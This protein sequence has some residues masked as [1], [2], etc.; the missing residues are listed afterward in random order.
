MALATGAKLGPYEIVSRIGKGGM[1]E[2]WKARDPR[3]NR[4]VAIKI[5]AQQFTDR[6]EREARAIAALNHP[7]ICTLY[8]VG[9]NYLVMELVEGPTLAERIAQGP[10]PLEEALAIAKQIADALE[11]A[12]DKAIVHRDLK[13]GNVKI[14][15]DRQVKVLDFGL[16]KSGEIAE[17]TSDSP[18]MLTVAGMIL[19]TA[20]Y[21]APEQARGEVVDKRADIWAFGVVFYEMLAGKRLFDGKTVSDTLASVLMREPD[22][23]RIPAKVKRLLRAC[24]QKDARN[25]LQAIGDSRLLLE[26]EGPATEAAP[27][28]AAPSKKLRLY[29]SAA[30]L[31]AIVAL[32][33]TGWLFWLKAE[34]PARITRFQVP[35]PENTTFNTYLSLSPD[36]RKLVF[37]AT[38]TPGGLWIRDLEALEWRHL[39]GTEG[40]Q[41][42]FWSPDSRF[43]GFGVQNQLKK[44]EVS[45]GP[46]QTL[47]ANPAG[48]MGTGAWNRDG[49]IVFG[50]RGAGPLWKISQAGGVPTALTTIDSPRGETFHALPTFM[51][52]GKHFIYLRSGRPEVAGIYAGSVDAKPEQQ[53]RERILAVRLAASYVNGSLF[54]MRENTLM[55]QPF[56]T[57]RLQLRGDPVPVA[58]GLAIIG[59][60][61]VFSVSPGGALAY[62][63]GDQGAN[64]QLTWFDRQ[65]KI[66]S[67]FGQPGPDQSIVLSPDGTRGAVRDA[68]GGT[69]GDLWTLDF[70]RGVRTRFTFRQS[71]G[72]WGVWS[73]D[74]S[75][76]A[77]PAGNLL[78][79]VYEKAASGAGDE[80]E[81]LK[82]PGKIHVPTSWSRDGRFLLF[83]INA[84]PKTGQDL[85]VLPLEGNRK[86][87]LLLDTE[88]NE[89]NAAFS[90]DMRWVAYASNESGRFEVYV[91]PFVASGPSGAPALGE[92]KW[93]VSKDGG[94]RPKWSADGKQI[95]F[96][97]PPNGTAKMAVDVKANGAAFEAA[98]PQR[99]FLS[100]ADGGWDVTADGKRFLLA[101]PQGGQTAQ[102][103]ITVVL[104]WPALLQKK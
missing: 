23:E 17:L 54:F 6:F 5:S 88:F 56:D 97:A 86:P 84:V 87:A 34:P 72:S 13:P 4:D 99:L 21:M 91:R 28:V 104:N 7:N 66:L 78:E 41:S 70:A 38:G 10:I 1:G 26:E 51:P 71:F 20:A 32:G 36:G 89:R 25:R 29:Q 73:P 18:T 80:K 96:E 2:V 101:A 42:P 94:D 102:V 68:P 76:I 47:C 39:A 45:G 14:K 52:D 79:T 19:G 100:L 98:I 90:P 65:G 103:P 85:W 46:A 12:H 37:T 24:L 81:L 64:Y 61:G 75:R 67:T 93:Q 3:L 60:T 82:E 55:A 27:P 43:L 31:L 59:S 16:A 53:S 40:A 95:F 62:R 44:I 92:G 74:G 8:D 33:L 48:I 30:A 11:A 15:P 63:T 57:G 58:E 50:G 9:P 49:V 69:A 83:H 77:F 22:W 35:L